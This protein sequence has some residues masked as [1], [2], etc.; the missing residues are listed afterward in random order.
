MN[1]VDYTAKSLER[2]LSSIAGKKLICYGAGQGFIE[3]LNIVDFTDKIGLLVD[4]NPALHGTKVGGVEVSPPQ[5]LKHISAD[6]AVVCVTSRF[7]REIKADLEKQGFRKTI[8]L[9]M[10]FQNKAVLELHQKQIGYL[11]SFIERIP[12]DYFQNIA[13]CKN[14]KK[15][16]VFI[17]LEISRYPWPFVFYLILLKKGYQVSLAIYTRFLI[18]SIYRSYDPEIGSFVVKEFKKMAGFASQRLQIPSPLFFGDGNPADK[19]CAQDAGFIENVSNDAAIW[20][21]GLKGASVYTDDEIVIL[22]KQYAQVYLS[23]L[24]AFLNGNPLDRAIVFSD[25]YTFSET[26]LYLTKDTGV[27]VATYESGNNMMR[28]MARGNANHMLDLRDTLQGHYLQDKAKRRIAHEAEAYYRSYIHK[29]FTEDMRGKVFTNFVESTLQPKRGK[30]GLQFDIIMPLNVDYDGAALK[31]SGAFRCL[32]DWLFETLA[33]LSEH[34]NATVAIREHPAYR[35][36]DPP[37]RIL[38]QEELARLCADNS[39]F[40]YIRAEDPINTYQLAEN[41]KLVLPWSSSV[42]IEAALMGKCVITAQNVYY[43]FFDFVLKATGKQDYFQ[44]IL[45]NLETPKL[46]ANVDDA[47]AL[48]Y[49]GKR[50]WLQTGCDEFHGFQDLE[51]GFLTKHLADIIEDAGIQKGIRILADDYPSPLLLPEINSRITYEQKRLLRRWEAYKSKFNLA[52]IL[53]ANS[54]RKVAIYGG[55]LIGEKL[56]AEL[57]ASPVEID[58]VIDQ[59][60]DIDFPN[61]VPA[62]DMDSYLSQSDI[63]AVII[64]PLETK[65]ILLNKIKALTK[66]KALCVDDLIVNAGWYTALT[67]LI[68]H[69]KERRA[70][71][72]M[73]RI[74]NAIHNIKNPTPW[75]SYLSYY[76]Q[77]PGIHSLFYTTKYEKAVESFYDDI[78]YVSSEYVSEVVKICGWLGGLEFLAKETPYSYG[79][80]LDKQSK[81]LNIINGQRVVIGAPKG[82]DKTIYFIGGCHIL[83]VHCE[84]QYTLQSSLQKLLNENPIQ[85]IRYRMISYSEPPDWTLALKKAQNMELDSGDYLFFIYTESEGDF[86]YY[87]KDVT[88]DFYECSNSFDRPHEFGEIFFDRIHVNHRGYQLLAK[89]LY[90]ILETNENGGKALSSPASRAKGKREVK[91]TMSPELEAYVEYARG[92]INRTFAARKNTGSIVMNCNPFTKGHRYLIE[93]AAKMCDAIIVFVVE[94]DRS[95]FPFHDRF[96]MVKWGTQD[97]ENVLVLRS[98]KYILSETTMSEYFV[99]SAVKDIV[100]DASYDLNIFSQI[101][102]PALQIN[103]RFVGE[104]PIDAVTRQYNHAM[105]ETFDEIEV[106]ELKRLGLHD[107]P[108][109]ASRVRALLRQWKDD[110]NVMDEIKELVP[111]TTLCYLTNLLQEKGNGEF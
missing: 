99:K 18:D 43:S 35:F 95:Y 80:L 24:S 72:V 88:V 28:Y 90:R 41:A 83:G 67:Q 84:D 6:D 21:E 36:L 38:Y 25:A 103:K 52:E 110:K 3:L 73:C 8:N 10:L 2:I 45:T 109:S 89:S 91:I 20:I 111:E 54:I 55:G 26:L 44:K 34:T 82:Y 13:P 87:C 71:L 86:S 49:M 62:S 5:T 50:C 47:Y 12:E 60:P 100:I 106:I 53:I 15:I 96:E 22:C 104:E 31:Y 42:G 57:Q 105:L 98:G 23:G 85:D 97:I 32:R 37:P 4:S 30:Q 29:E 77:S 81:Y 63:D 75:E 17:D 33:F 40:R 78:P 9:N 39:R 14:Q 48:Y 59:N 92:E 101:I 76:P 70:K 93:T 46:P 64:T 102:A 108:I 68:G 107:S 27:S 11:Y 69:V 58:C 19:P 94:E 79:S 65:Y 61:V 1:V 16:V 7:Y 74:D 56:V 51:S 66:A